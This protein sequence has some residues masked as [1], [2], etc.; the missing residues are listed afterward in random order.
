MLTRQAAALLLGLALA[1]SGC[2]GGDGDEAAQGDPTRTPRDA[3][4]SATASAMPTEEK[5]E[6]VADQAAVEGYMR[7][8]FTG[9]SW[10]ALITR[11]EVTSMWVEVETQLFPDS[12][13]QEP[14]LSICRAV[15][16][17]PHENEGFLPVRVVGSNGEKIADNLA[18]GGVDVCESEV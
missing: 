18:F 6:V 13:A 5:S 8:N 4:P 14:G 11:Y 10:F 2:G 12:D 3:L 9:A 7:D 17:A 15:M 1:T 16:Q